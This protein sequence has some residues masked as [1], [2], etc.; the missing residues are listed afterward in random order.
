MP[1]GS[2]AGPI[3]RE[4]LMK[5]VLWV[6]A[7][8]LLS[9][10]AFGQSINLPFGRGDPVSGLAIATTWCSSCHLVGTTQGATAQV[11]VPTFPAMARRL[12]TDL[13][14]LAAFIADPHPPMPNLTLSRQDIRD[15][16]AYIATLK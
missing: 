5:R 7:A 9:S 2:A 15:V 4:E 14:V 10:G 8:V 3:E 13:D 16:L 6:A 11:D 12:P 1:Q